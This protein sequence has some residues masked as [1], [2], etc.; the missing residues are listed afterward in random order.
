MPHGD[1]AATCRRRHPPPPPPSAT[2]AHL[3]P[4]E[5]AHLRVE[6]LVVLF[7]RL[8]D[9]KDGLQTLRALA[10]TL[11]VSVS[12][13]R[14]L[15][16]SLSEMWPALLFSRVCTH[17]TAE[18]PTQ[19]HTHMQAGAHSSQ[20]IQLPHPDTRAGVRHDTRPPPLNE[21]GHH[22][23]THTGLMRLDLHALTRSYTR[24]DLEQGVGVSEFRVERFGG[25]VRGTYSLKDLEQVLVKLLVRL[26]EHHTPLAVPNQHV[27][28]PHTLDHRS[29]HGIND[30]SNPIALSPVKHGFHIASQK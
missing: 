30:V 1:T 10:V 26:P 4:R 27:C 28:R 14:P 16:L 13:S 5:R 17:S 3:A 18:N 8:A 11:N 2:L 20:R 12:C 22:V 19:V 7:L 21:S 25:K 23:A 6:A 29:L 15:Y 24:R 9:A